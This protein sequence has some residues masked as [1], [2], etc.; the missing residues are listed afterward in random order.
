MSITC[1]T[2]PGGS[3]RLICTCFTCLERLQGVQPLTKYA[4]RVGPLE[5]KTLR[6]RGGRCGGLICTCFTCPGG[7]GRLICTCFT[8]LGGSDSNRPNIPGGSAREGPY[9][10][11]GEGGEGSSAR[12]LRVLEALGSLFVGILRV[13]EV[14]GEGSGGVQI[15]RG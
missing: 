7:S 15:P 2:C 14:L 10:C 9:A 12:V 13:L 6:V 11:G 3:G 4:S 1:F 8:C 5:K